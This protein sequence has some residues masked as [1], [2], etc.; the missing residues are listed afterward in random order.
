MLRGGFRL[1]GL[2]LS[3]EQKIA[4]ELAVI[5]QADGRLD[6][7][8]KKPYIYNVVCRGTRKIAQLQ[9]LGR[10]LTYNKS[11]RVRCRVEY[12]EV[13]EW[14]D[15]TK[16][17]NF[18]STILEY[19]FEALT[20]FFELI[21]K[22]DGDYTRGNTY[23]QSRSRRKYS[24]DIVQAVAAML[25]KSTSYYRHPTK[26]FDCV[27]FNASAIRSQSRTIVSRQHYKGGL[28]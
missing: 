7:R 28:S 27:N 4:L 17:K 23:G 11:G 16:E 14:L 15:D 12:S 22:W 5:V 13:A 20:Y 9:R 1:S 10:P 6:T 3:K 25:G 26:D 24:V 2:S 21:H 19:N 18:L 8:S